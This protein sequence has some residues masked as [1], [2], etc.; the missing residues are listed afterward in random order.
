MNPTDRQCAAFL[1]PPLVFALHTALLMAFSVRTR[2]AD[3]DNANLDRMTRKQALKFQRHNVFEDIDTTVDKTIDNFAMAR[4]KV[5]QR[6]PCPGTDVGCS[7]PSL[8][9]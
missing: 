9:P 6:F 1:C 4:T 5:I 8:A 3:P 7:L 2:F